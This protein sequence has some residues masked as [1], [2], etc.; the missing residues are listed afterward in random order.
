MAY[1]IR[2][3]KSSNCFDLHL[4]RSMLSPA[5]IRVKISIRRMLMGSYQGSLLIWSSL[6]RIEEEGRWFPGVQIASAAWRQGLKSFEGIQNAP[7]K[8]F[9]RGE[10]WWKWHDGNLFLPQRRRPGCPPSPPLTCSPARRSVFLPWKYN[11][12]IG[13]LMS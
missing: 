6:G 8:T 4:T 12:Q 11:F 9:P 13:W 2:N 5:S 1:I 3:V 10:C 7:L